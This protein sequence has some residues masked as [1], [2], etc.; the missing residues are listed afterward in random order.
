MSTANIVKTEFVVTSTDTEYQVPG[1]WTAEQIKASYATQVPGL[2]NFQA[3]ER[4]ED[5][6]E[7]RVRIITFSP[8]TGTKG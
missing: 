3:T 8:R 2:N 4:Y 6:Q 7:G 1:N 5:R